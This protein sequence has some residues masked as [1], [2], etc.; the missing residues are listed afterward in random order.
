MSRTHT[1]I[2]DDLANYIREVT[3]REPEALRKLREESENHPRASMQ[4]SPEQGQFLH[5]MALVTAA[6]KTL[7]VGVFMGYSSTWVALALRSGGKVIACDVSEEY[8]TRA[9]QTW[10]E[11]GVQDRVE[12]RLAPALESLD[13]MLSDGQA[14]SFDFAFIDADKGNYA[15]YYERAMQLLRPGGLIA[16]DNVLWDGSVIDPS[17]QS[18]DTEAIRAFNRKLHSDSR[19]ALSM[20][21]M[22][23]GLT[24]ACKL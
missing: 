12:L 14:G 16:V 11:A 1:P 2:T 15:N 23:D 7:E 8:T 6:R 9:R 18:A 4:T 3:L 19:V 10:R 21:T 17:D 22:G 24:L 20:A 13:G 5:L